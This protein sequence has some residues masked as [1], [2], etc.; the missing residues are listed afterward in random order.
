MAHMLSAFLRPA[1]GNNR[2]AWRSKGKAPSL[3]NVG[4]N[5][6]RRSTKGPRVDQ[7]MR[8]KGSSEGPPF[9]A[10]R[11]HSPTVRRR[12]PL[13]AG[14]IIGSTS[15][16]ASDRTRITQATS[17]RCPAGFGCPHRCPRKKI[18]RLT[19]GAANFSRPPCHALSSRLAA[20]SASALIV[21]E[22]KPSSGAFA[23]GRRIHGCTSTGKRASCAAIMPSSAICARK[24]LI[25]WSAVAVKDPASDAASTGSAVRPI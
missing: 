4:G 24:A 12:P 23:C 16:S 19:R 25:S 15:H 20:L 9:C 13:L 7:D 6:R 1:N 17:I 10:P 3:L 8:P 2:R 21:P 22:A 14:G 18:M 11:A 5:E